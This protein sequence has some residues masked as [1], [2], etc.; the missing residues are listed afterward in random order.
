MIFFYLHFINIK[1]DR[2]CQGLCLCCVTFVTMT[3]KEETTAS[4]DDATIGRPDL[5]PFD[6]IKKKN[7]KN[8]RKNYHT[9]CYGYMETSHETTVL[10]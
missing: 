4:I 7:K 6:L 2:K 3:T 1:G 5:K 8:N 10:K 9:H